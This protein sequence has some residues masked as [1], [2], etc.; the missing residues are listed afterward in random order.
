MN[1]YFFMYKIKF[2]DDA[3]RY[4][5]RLPKLISN[6]IF[7]KIENTKK[8]PYRYFIRLKGRKEYKLRVGSYRV[9]VDINDSEII[10]YVVK[11]GHRDKI[12]YNV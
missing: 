11:I 4:L 10:I 3:I 1:F 2:D 5:R 9:I 8:D 12:Y 6:R 7:T